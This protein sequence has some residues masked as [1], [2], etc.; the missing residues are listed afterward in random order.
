MEILAYSWLKPKDN[1]SSFRKFDDKESIFWNL[2]DRG[3]TGDS[4]DGAGL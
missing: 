3:E 2:S 1:R 4:K